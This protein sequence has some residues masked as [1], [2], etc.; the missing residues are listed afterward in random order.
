MIFLKRQDY[1]DI[2]AYAEDGLPNEVCGLLAVSL[3]EKK[4]W[5]K[6]YII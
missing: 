4:S 5:L 3:T 6:K 2:I 1:L